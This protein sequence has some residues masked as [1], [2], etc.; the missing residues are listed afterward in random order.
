MGWK[1]WEENSNTT[2]ALCFICSHVMINLVELGVFGPFLTRGN[3][4]V[5]IDENL[6]RLTRL[7]LAPCDGIVVL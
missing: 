2:V 3:I 6:G 5:W 1:R 7:A 4:P